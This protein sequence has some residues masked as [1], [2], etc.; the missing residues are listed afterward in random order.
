MNEETKKL[1][2]SLHYYLHE[3]GVHEMDALVHNICERQVLNMIYYLSKQCGCDVKVDIDAKEEGGIID[4]IKVIAESAVFIFLFEKGVEYMF[5]P[6]KTYLDNAKTR[7]EI[8]EM[9]KHSSFTE[10][11]VEALVGEDDALKRFTSSYYN[12]LSKENTVDKVETT[13][14]NNDD[15]NDSVT[16]TVHKNNFQDKVIKRNIEKNKTTITATTLY[17]GSPILI[18]GFPDRWKG[19]YN[20]ESILFTIN[21]NEFL[22]QVYN[23]EV[24]FESGTSLTCDLEITEHIKA[25]KVVKRTYEV[26]YVRA[27][28]DGSHYQTNTKRYIKEI[29][30]GAENREP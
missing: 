22:D 12:N 21:D 23:R 30:E 24:K 11:E 14:T 25:D 17:V 27:W 20:G 15:A 1:S 29:E 18:D 3:E 16:F 26:L 13:L 5:N 2:I 28:C 4:K 8:A 6:D 10:D 7:I 19:V 9:I